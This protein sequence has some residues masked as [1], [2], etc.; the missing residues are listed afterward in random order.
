[1]FN[2]NRNQINRSLPLD[3]S[4]ETHVFLLLLPLF[5]IIWPVPPPA[6]SWCKEPGSVCEYCSRQVERVTLCDGPG[7]Q[8]LRKYWSAKTF[9]EE[10]LMSQPHGVVN[11]GRSTGNKVGERQS[12]DRVDVEEKDLPVGAIVCVV[13]MIVVCQ[14]D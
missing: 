3:P 1:M 9:E 2:T 6:S 8:S 14:G 12:S 13:E 4:S 10:Q 11:I 7:E 5:F